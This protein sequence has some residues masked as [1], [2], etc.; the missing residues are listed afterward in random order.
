MNKLQFN[1]KA[2]KED[3]ETRE[4]GEGRTKPTGSVLFT[5]RGKINLII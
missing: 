4:V 2:L 3:R 1:I 5:P